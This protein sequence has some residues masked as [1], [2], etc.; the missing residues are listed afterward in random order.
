MRIFGYW[1]ILVALSISVVAA[2][3]SIIGLVAI[4]AAAAIPVIIMG[5]V[6]EI[7]KITTAIW[8]HVNWKR[9]QFLIKTYLTIATFLL[10][11][12]TSMGIFGFLSKAHIEQ[13]AVAVEGV[14]QLERI[15]TEISRSNDEIARAEEKIV[16]LENSSNSADTSLQEKI[17]TEEARIATVY[18]RLQQDISASNGA[19]EAAIAPY[20]AQQ[21]EADRV[22][23]Q[24]SEYVAANNIRALQGLIGARQDGQYGTR[25]AN[26]VQAFREKQEADRN[27]A[28]E[29]IAERRSITR[30]ETARLRSAADIQIAQ[31]N[32]LINRLRSQLGTTSINDVEADIQEQRSRIREAEA[33][34]DDLFERK[35]TI[36][37]E[38]RKL[39]AEVGPVKYIAELV[40]GEEAGRDT[41]EQSVR[42][43]I[44]LLVVVFDPLAVVLVI[45]G[46][47][48]VEQNPRKRKDRQHDINRTV[49]RMETPRATT[50]ARKNSET[51]ENT[52]EKTIIDV[53]VDLPLAVDT[54]ETVAVD[55]WPDADTAT[56]TP[57]STKAIEYKGVYY[58]PTHHAYD[59]VKEQIELNRTVRQT[60][61][62]TQL[63]NKVVDGIM[64]APDSKGNDPVIVKKRIED[65]INNDSDIKKLLESAD[66]ETL[67]EVYKE[68]IKDDKS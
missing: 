1:T 51:D 4:F 32:E 31:S 43:V 3:Y 26:A 57:R 2:Y 5:S 17:A 24:I 67:R 46:I 68:I 56:E 45:S 19:L 16:K 60:Q 8:L 36:E 37:T 10:M 25:T 48:L 23:A 54:L 13:T 7:G 53:D 47:S 49:P 42:W 9:A 55:A 64:S 11:F 63:I 30:E 44:L 39:E 28:L 27:T 41:L 6:L 50:N 59:R 66:E 40:Y 15:E 22:L 52:F 34:L 21:E 61:E 58:E 12:I 18:E 65:A 62:K 33:S 14:A 20:T 29:Q 35:Y 38:A